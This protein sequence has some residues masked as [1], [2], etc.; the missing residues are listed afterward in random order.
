[1][2]F[3]HLAGA[4]QADDTTIRITGRTAGATP[5]ISKL[6]LEVSIQPF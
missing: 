6:A 4:S 2:V 1:M 3:T 5:F